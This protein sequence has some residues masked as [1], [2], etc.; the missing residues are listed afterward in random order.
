MT[1]CENDLSSVSSDILVMAVLRLKKID[2]ENSWLTME[3][4][5]AI[6]TAVMTSNASIDV[7]IGGNELLDKRFAHVTMPGFSVT[8]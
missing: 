3:Q 4:C 1:L 2:I 5:N 8:V 7:N 6:L